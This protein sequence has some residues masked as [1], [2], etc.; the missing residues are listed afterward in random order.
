MKCSVVFRSIPGHNRFHPLDPVNP[1][2]TS[3]FFCF[4][5]CYFLLLIVNSA[6]SGGRVPEL[7]AYVLGY[8]EGAL[9][10]L[11]VGLGKIAAGL[12]YLFQDLFS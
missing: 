3:F 4:D 2:R 9:C 1:V 7:D 8:L 12:F 6:N 5:V 10:K 11:L